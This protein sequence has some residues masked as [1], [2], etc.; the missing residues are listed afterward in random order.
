MLH[1]HHIIPRHAGGTDDSSNIETIT[2]EEHAQRHKDLW[3]KFGRQQDKDAW[4][5]LSGI[6]TK[7]EIILEAQRRAGRI[8]GA[9]NSREHM[10]RIAVLG[11]KSKKGILHTAEAKKKISLAHRGE[12]NYFFGKKHSEEAKIKISATHKGKI[13]WNRGKQHSPETK[14]KIRTSWYRRNPKYA[15]GNGVTNL[16]N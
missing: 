9:K 5:A 4:Q 12:K 2:I 10:K 6:I 14:E 16:T 8:A 15:H 3:N 13:P 7:K 11:G 1:R